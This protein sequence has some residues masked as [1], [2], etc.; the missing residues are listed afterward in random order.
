MKRDFL[1]ELGLADDLIDKILDENGKDI[2]REK[3]KATQAKEDLAAVQEQLTARDKDIEELKK[4]SGDAEDIRKQLEELQGKY[5]KETEAYKAQLAD[6]DY[7]DAM[8]R[9]VS[10]KGIKFSS[11]AAE[12]AYLADL[13]EKHLTLKDGALDGFEEWHKA[14]VEADPTAFQTGKPAPTFA[15]PVGGGGGSPAIEGIGAMYAKQ[16]NAQYAAQP[17]TT[18][19]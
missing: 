7:S 14:Q 6:R 5:T 16:F 18:K 4:T 15:K 17:T 9:A 10:A 1:K 2:D 13:K 11:K 3:Q 19:E 8:N 12:K